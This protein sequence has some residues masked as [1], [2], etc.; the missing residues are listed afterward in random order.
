MGSPLGGISV[1]FVPDGIHLTLLQ[2]RRLGF[3]PHSLYHRVHVFADFAGIVPLLLRKFET[4]HAA[5]EERWGGRGRE[6]DAE[7]VGTGWVGT[8]GWG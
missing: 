1:V 3:L 4:E 2:P 8:G 5:R 6:C 7:W